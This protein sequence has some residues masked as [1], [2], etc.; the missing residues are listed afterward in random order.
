M[1]NKSKRF[2][3]NILDMSRRWFG[4]L[5]F[6]PRCP[7]C[8]IILEPEQIEKGIHSSCERKL[9]P[10][11]GAVCMHCGRPFRKNLRKNP[12]KS[13]EYLDDS[14]QEYCQECLKRGYVHP[15]TIIKSGKALYMYRGKIKQTMYRLKYSNK[16][17]YAV[18]FAKQ[19]V[20]MYPWFFDVDAIIPVPMY[21]KKEKLRGYNQA[22]VLAKALAAITNV[23]VDNKVVCRIRNTQPQKELNDIQRKNNLKNAFQKGKSIVKYK[24][25]LIVD[26]I[27]TTGA[28]VETVAEE[29]KCIGIRQVYVLCIC[30]GGEL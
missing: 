9:F 18:F 17:E 21:R 14:I 24:K 10:I 15:G 28:T 30:I 11:Y 19:A 12:Y 8:D 2:W 4:F 25:V 5:L 6:P 16:R 29:L 22:E 1:T 23:P 7:V 26:D 27:Y 20:Q 13:N 3:R